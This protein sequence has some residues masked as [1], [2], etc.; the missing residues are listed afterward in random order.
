MPKPTDEPSRKARKAQDVLLIVLSDMHSGSTTALFPNRQWQ[1]KHQNHSPSAR[2]LAIWRHWKKCI[3][4]FRELRKGK[5]VVLVVNGDAIEGFHHGTREI[6]SFDPEEHIEIHV[7]LMDEFMRGIGFSD[8]DEL[9]YVAG[10]ESHTGDREEGAAKDLG[11]VKRNGRWISEVLELDINGKLAVFTH[12][13]PAANWGAEE[14]NALRLWLR[15]IY[16]TYLRAGRRIPD[17]V[18]TG[19]YHTPCYNTFVMD[20]HTMHG[21]ICASLQAKTRYAYKMAPV[22]INRVGVT[23]AVIPTYA[24]L[25]VPE[26]TLLDTDKL[27]ALDAR[28]TAGE[29]MPK[30]GKK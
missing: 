11:A 15:R 12:H 3:E 19:H 27:P 25:Y 30:K 1:G 29:A 9:Y 8:G 14:G 17:L 21:S 22:Q 28:G 4:E 10:T 6:V 5:R 26:P 20:Y 23:Y 13:G 18:M 16:F 2:Q 7:E 24:P